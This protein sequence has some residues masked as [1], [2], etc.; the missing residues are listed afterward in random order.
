M[1]FASTFSVC[2]ETMFQPHCI[3]LCLEQL[4]TAP[5]SCISLP[6]SNMKC[7]RFF[8]DVKPLIQFT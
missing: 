1:L 8:W 2:A 7:K 6:H 5:C 4:R 3:V